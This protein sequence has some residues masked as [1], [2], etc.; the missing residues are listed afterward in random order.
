MNAIAIKTRRAE[1]RMRL[2]AEGMRA[3]CLKGNRPETP[4]G[5]SGEAS[6]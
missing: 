5:V 6:Q 2:R 1:T 4:A 3:R